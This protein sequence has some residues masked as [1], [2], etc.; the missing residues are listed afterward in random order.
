MRMCSI[1]HT[2]NSGTPR[3]TVK[4]QSAGGLKNPEIEL[5]G[6][7]KKNREIWPKTNAGIFFFF[8]NFFF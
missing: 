3:D 5:L 8:V 2:A 7:E 4:I 6:Q 1:F